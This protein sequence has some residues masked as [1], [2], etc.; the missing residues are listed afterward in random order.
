VASP[1]V[2]A[3][4]AAREATQAI[5]EFSALVEQTGRA[6]A[7]AL[8]QQAQVLDLTEQVY[9]GAVNVRRLIKVALSAKPGGATR[10][11]RGG[12]REK[13]AAHLAAH[14]GS[15]F[16]PYELSRVLGHSSGAVVTALDKLVQ[17]GMAVQTS[18][19]PLR[20]ASS[21]ASSSATAESS[22]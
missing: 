22:A 9:A 19:R 15:E 7:Q 13:I 11:P 5:A 8:D 18:E 16:S 14:S 1:D 17:L 20:F 21:S 3:A 10:M 2:G 12:L 6:L 4:H